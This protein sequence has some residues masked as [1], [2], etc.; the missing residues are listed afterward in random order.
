[1]LNDLTPW[2]YADAVLGVA[3]ELR[4]TIVEINPAQ[5]RNMRMEAM[6]RELR[7]LSTWVKDSQRGAVI[8]KDVDRYR[9]VESQR[10]SSASPLS[11]GETS[12]LRFQERW[13]AEVEG[14]DLFGTM[15]VGRVASVAA[16]GAVLGIDTETGGVLWRREN[17]RLE[18]RYHVVGMDGLARA[19]LSG[20]IEMFDLMSGV[21][22]WRTQLS[23]R[24]G[25]KP[26]LLV[27]E[28][29]PS[30][31]LV[32]AAEEER[33]LVA[34]D[35]RTGEPRWRFTST[36]GGGF[37]LRRFGRLL[38]VVSDDGNFNAVD[39]DDGALV[40][41]FTERTRFVTPAA[42]WRDTVLALGGGREVA[43]GQM[44][45]LDALSGE[46]K[47][48]ASL[49]AG[50]PM[51]PIIAGN[52]ALVPIRSSQRD[53][54]VALDLVSGEVRWRKACEGA[55]SQSALMALDDCI[56]MNAPGG[57]MRAFSAEDGEE[58]WTTVLGPTCSDDVPFNLKVVLRGGMLFVPA[59]TIYVV[60]P[61]DGRVIHSLGGEPP[62]PD[63]LQVDPSLAV[64]VCEDSG[65]I[66]M[67]D[68]VSRLSVVS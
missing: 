64:F 33:K 32:L 54:L 66:G 23:P 65:H 68:L 22:R 44:Y 11:V 46:F 28:H 30:P 6:S 47:W 39:I 12:R 38:Y 2:E 8:N 9:H 26:L 18:A 36:R 10:P 7:A 27:A 57:V 52:T 19:S 4:R 17:D 59:D 21:L 13:R 60:R 49:G 58:R 48:R 45:A 53:E 24:S 29:G 56:I 43:E 20:Q 1:V 40:W 63:L 15:L 3:R 31:G 5:R 35:I 67:Y 16:K 42:L 50:V 14:L 25:G 62:V 55:E 51:F 37:A 61:E 34:L 41:R